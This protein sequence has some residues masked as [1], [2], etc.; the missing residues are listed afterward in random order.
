MR[1]PRQRKKL[2]IP[3]EG[4]PPPPKKSKTRFASQKSL[5]NLFRLNLD[6]RSVP[7][8]LVNSFRLLTQLRTRLNPPEPVTLPKKGREIGG[9]PF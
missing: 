3:W 9:D 6:A 5:K 7:E 1:G 2:H 8:A 4:V